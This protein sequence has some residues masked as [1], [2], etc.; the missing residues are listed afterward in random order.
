[1][2]VDGAQE[3]ER[4]TSRR[5]AYETPRRQ[6][7]VVDG[8][9]ADLK[10]RGRNFRC[11]RAN[12]PLSLAKPCVPPV[13]KSGGLGALPVGNSSHFEESGGQSAKPMKSLQH[14]R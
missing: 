13:C 4:F 8:R 3:Q 9:E 2:S 14:N 5:S 11:W 12:R 10:E 1:M 6:L 7:D